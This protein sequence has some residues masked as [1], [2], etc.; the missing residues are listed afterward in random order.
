MS[1]SVYKLK[2]FRTKWCSLVHLIAITFPLWL[3]SEIWDLIFLRPNYQI[4]QSDICI[5]IYIYI[6]C[7]QKLSS[8]TFNPSMDVAS[9]TG[10]P[11]FWWLWIGILL[12]HSP[13]PRHAHTHLHLTT[14]FL[15]GWDRNFECR[16]YPE[17]C[18]HVI[19]PHTGDQNWNQV[20]DGAILV[21]DNFSLTENK[22]KH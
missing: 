7:Q 4:R 11:P 5:Y 15:G 21:K 8:Q 16:F 18:E 3:P 12:P 14:P 20:M 13:F 10:Y 22:I 6:Y 17:I 19:H 1:L 2:C 9:N